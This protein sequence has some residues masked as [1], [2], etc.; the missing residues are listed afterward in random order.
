MALSQTPAELSHHLATI[1][2]L[3]DSLY[4]S[5][6]EST[7]LINLAHNELGLLLRVLAAAEARSSLL[8]AD[9]SIF[10]LDEKLEGCHA[11]LLDLQMLQRKPGGVGSSTQ[12]AEIRARISSFVFELNVMNADMTIY[13][14]NKVNRLVRDFIEDVREGKRG[15]SVI[16][17]ALNDEASASEKEEAWENLQRELHDVGLVP[18]LSGQDHEFIV[19]TLRKA[20][21]D[22]HLLENIKP[23]PEIP[24]GPT[25]IVSSP[26]QLDQHE[27]PP[28]LPPRPRDSG[29]SDLSEKQVVV[30]EDFPIPAATELQGVSDT[31]KQALPIDNYPIPVVT[32]AFFNAVG[33][34]DK[35]ALSQDN[36]SI[37]VTTKEHLSTANGFD[38]QVI[39]RDSLSMPLDTEYVA[40]G[41]SEGS[42][43]S[44]PPP[45]AKG[46]KPSLMNKVKYRLTNSKESFISS[47]QMGGAYSVK[48]ALDKGAD[49][50]T[51]N[52]H[53]QTALMV[54][55]SFGHEDVVKLLL[56]YGAD[57][58]KV[59][60]KRET[61]LGVAA[62]RGMESIVRV[63]LAHGANMNSGMNAK[64]ALIEA[65]SSGYEN[66]V[67]LMLDRGANPN[68][69]G[70]GGLSALTEAAMNGH[71]NICRLLLDNGART[72]QPNSSLTGR[73]ALWKAVYQGRTAVVELLMERGAD[74]LWKDTA[75]KTVLSLASA[76]R[77]S[78]ILKI[79]H[80]YGYESTPFQ[81]Y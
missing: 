33:D 80:Q 72:E 79:F 3:A 48:L 23:T 47:I 43:T 62:A 10:A 73:T 49:V 65:A 21:E 58:A 4:D 24:A 52:H 63:L 2:P 31:E 70:T 76:Y 20:V 18:G 8:C 38:K 7:A 35:Q 28:S 14:Q 22:D 30:T 69:M 11:I 60:M 26:S 19:S 13:S 45:L 41:R 51:M 12:I 42:N 71:V 32:E 53:N 25:I 46:K 39:S 75:G 37:P 40:R 5:T 56:D 59:S 6:R 74:P 78:E 77:R 1:R 57:T 16:T 36:Y 67:R 55:C 68:A 64:P 17:D 9:R 27:C 29:L 81:Y 66:I 54:A 15:R 44:A 34:S 61:A 50:N